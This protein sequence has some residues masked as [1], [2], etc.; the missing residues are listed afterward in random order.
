MTSTFL[1]LGPLGLTAS[2]IAPGDERA[3]IELPHLSTSITGLS[4]SLDCVQEFREALREVLD[5]ESEHAVLDLSCGEGEFGF[6]MHV[7]R[8]SADVFD[9]VIRITPDAFDQ[10]TAFGDAVA[11]QARYKVAQEALESART[12][13]FAS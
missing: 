9:V 5:R 12:E 11:Y 4:E 13:S 7:A 3:T 2:V 6:V 10:T 8:A 1:Q